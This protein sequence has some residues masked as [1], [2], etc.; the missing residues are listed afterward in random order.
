[1]MAAVSRDSPGLFP[2]LAAEE[3]RPVNS[4][5]LNIRIPPGGQD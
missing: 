4:I 5:G 3:P 1:M 2:P